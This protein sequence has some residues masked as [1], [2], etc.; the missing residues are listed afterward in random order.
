MID[1]DWILLKDWIGTTWYFILEH[2][3][4]F[5]WIKILTSQWLLQGLAKRRQHY[6]YISHCQSLSGRYFTEILNVK[7]KH[8]GPKI[9]EKKMRVWLAQ[10]GECVSMKG[11]GGW[12]SLESFLRVGLMLWHNFLLFHFSKCFFCVI[13]SC[14]IGF[15]VIF[16]DPG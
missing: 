6:S 3:P 2:S 8:L 9:M 13:K 5:P 7:L 10:S 1:R 16:V 11:S 15:W 14:G 4:L 12:S